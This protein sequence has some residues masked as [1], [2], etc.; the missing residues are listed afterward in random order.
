MAF[1]VSPSLS[2]HRCKPFRNNRAAKAAGDYH[3]LI[4]HCLTSIIISNVAM[5][6]NL[7]N[8]SSNPAY[9]AESQAGAR[10]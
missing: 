10:A 3:S 1:S 2:G 7:G 8:G 6:S 4:S 5:M 9:V